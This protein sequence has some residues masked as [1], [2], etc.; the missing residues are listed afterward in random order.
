[1]HVYGVEL[2]NDVVK[3]RLTGQEIRRAGKFRINR[4]L[5]P[6]NTR[7]GILVLM[8]KPESMTDLVDCRV[9]VPIVALVKIHGSIGLGNPQ[10]VPSNIRTVGGRSE[11]N[12]NAFA[13]QLISA[14]VLP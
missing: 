3:R 7:I 12:P 4:L 13:S 14:P 6:H 8:G 5:V 9:D 1:M 10:Y 11:V 2:A